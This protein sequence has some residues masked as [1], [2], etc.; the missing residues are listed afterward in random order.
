[1]SGLKVNMHNPVKDMTYI[2]SY[3]DET[4]HCTLNYEAFIDEEVVDIDVQ[5][6]KG[7]SRTLYCR[8][9]VIKNN[10]NTGRYDD[11]VEHKLVY[12]LYRAF[13]YAGL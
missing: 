5:G 9:N 7:F 10:H 4:K 13:T 3:Y 6:L 1:M 2:L 8:N 12:F 11:I